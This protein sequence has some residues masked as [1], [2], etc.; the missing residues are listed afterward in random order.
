MARQELETLFYWFTLILSG[1]N[2]NERGPY[3]PYPHNSL[4]CL[5][6]WIPTNEI[7]SLPPQKRARGQYTHCI[8][9]SMK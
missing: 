7:L 5:E 8:C 9:I 6:T 3:V 4:Q 2:T 1:K